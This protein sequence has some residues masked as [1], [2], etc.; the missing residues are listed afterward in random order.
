MDSVA[1]VSNQNLFQ[2]YFLW[3]TKLP[4]LSRKPPVP[5]PPMPLGR[6]LI[7]DFGRVCKLSLFATFCLWLFASPLVNRGFYDLMTL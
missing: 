1:P 4:G 6:R 5:E 3:F 2:R 7:R